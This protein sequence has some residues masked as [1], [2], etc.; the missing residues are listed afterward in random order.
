MTNKPKK[1]RKLTEWNKFV[2]DNSG[3][4]RF[5][6]PS[7]SPDLKAMSRAFKGGSKS[8][9]KP[10]KQTQTRSVRTTTK[11]PEKKTRKTSM[12]KAKTQAV[13]VGGLEK[14]TIKLFQQL[15][16]LRIALAIPRNDFKFTMTG[17]GSTLKVKGWKPIR[18][19]K[20]STVV[21]R[22]VKKARSLI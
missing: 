5:T 1:K 7:G 14:R 2:R 15:E 4:A 18:A 13:P 3:K 22:A 20:L 21:E 8:K 12:Q 19:R 9:S 17:R 6:L 11:K 10:R 16:Q